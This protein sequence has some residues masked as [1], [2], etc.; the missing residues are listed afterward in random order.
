[1]TRRFWVGLVLALPPV[2][3]EMGGHLVGAH[4]WVDQTLSN[5]ILLVFATPVVIPSGLIAS[6]MFAAEVA[7][8]LT[9]SIT[10]PVLMA[11]VFASHSFFSFSSSR[12]RE[13]PH[14]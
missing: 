10:I 9:D 1:M 2:V 13:C 14:V 3:L 11:F 6:T 12:P 7:I 5:W 8:S 4:A